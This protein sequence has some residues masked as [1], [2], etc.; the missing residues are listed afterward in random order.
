MRREPPGVLPPEPLA[1]RRVLVTGGSMG[2]GLACARAALSA[3]ARVTIAARGDAALRQAEAELNGCYPGRVH[4]LRADVAERAE[5]EALI[6][7]ALERL[8][9]LDG[10]VHAAAVQ[11]AIG[12]ILEVEP[13]EWLETIRIDLYGSFLVAR[14]AARAMRG[15]GGGRIVLFS[16]GGATSPF[17]NYTAYGCAKAGVARLAETIAAE[18][19][20]HGIAV[21]C[22]APGFVATRMHEATLAAGTRAGEAYLAR[23][24]AELER[25]GV[26]PEVAARAA[27]FL[28]SDAAEG[29]TGRL[30]AAPW[31]AWWEWPARLAELRGSDLFTL[32]RIVPRDRGADWQ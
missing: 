27:V 15:Q 13:E 9:G 22:L 10:V 8:G 19:A 4:A 23:T 16:G 11:G 5:V 18:L 7:G 26:S 1:G 25:G 32:R 20:P 2:I 17:P 30:L 29:I 21:N 12:S 14:A 6:A 28:L 24:R 3:G 31:D